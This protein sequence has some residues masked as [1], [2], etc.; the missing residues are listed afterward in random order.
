[1][2]YSRAIIVKLIVF[3][4]VDGSDVHAVRCSYTIQSLTGCWKGLMCRPCYR[5]PF[6]ATYLALSIRMCMSVYLCKCGWVFVGNVA[7]VRCLL[8]YSIL[9]WNCCCCR[10]I[11]STLVQP[12][13]YLFRIQWSICM[14]GYMATQHTHICIHVYM[15]NAMLMRNFS[16]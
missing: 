3:W 9:T 10:L 13:Q 2:L 8:C 6:C 4:Y 1:M 16:L 14:R 5:P 12:H 11:Y 7:Y 15:C